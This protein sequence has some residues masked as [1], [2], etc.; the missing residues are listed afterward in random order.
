MSLA[1]RV[2][3]WLGYTRA[4]SAPVKTVEVPRARG[5]IDNSLWTDE[6][7]RSW[8][9]SD[10]FSAKSAH[11]FWVRRQLRLRSRYEVSNNPYLWG[12]CCNNA[13]DLVGKGPTLKVATQ[14]S[15]YNRKVE[16]AW[17]EWADEVCLAEKVRT[18]KL[19]R[20]VDGEGFLILKSVST[21]E[22][23]VQLY[24]LDVEADQVTRPAPA[25]LPEL[26]VDGLELD[27]V[28]GRPVAFWVLRHHPGDFWFPDLNP[29]AADRLPARLVIHWFP[30][31]R[32]GQV[33]GV[34]IFTP[35]LDLFTELRAYRK[36]VLTKAQ[37]SANLTGVVESTAP[38]DADGEEELKPFER[39]ALDRGTL[40]YLG[41]GY[42]MAPYPSASPDT[43]YGE[44]HKHCLGEACRPLAYPLNLALG[45]SQEFNF[46]SAKLDHINYFQNL[47]TERKECER[48]VLNHLFRAWFEE[49]VMVPGLLPDGA[50]LGATPV[51]WHWPGFPTLDPGVD[52]K[53]EMD[54]LAS[55]QKTWRQ[56]WAE[57]GQDWRDMMAQQAV[58][59]EEIE[60]LGLSFGEPLKKTE[61]TAEGEE[62]A[63]A[64][65]GKGAV[66]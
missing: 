48:V 1:S 12:V 46:S 25:S 6:N 3:G 43:G 2:A 10:Y 62:G 40:T 39:I 41:A 18:C 63:P 15:R 27:E 65:Q 49:A 54:E 32:P 16:A 20:T 42:K 44:F 52:V 24:P 64:G 9:Q 30:K 47:R 37:I 51:E 34:P 19:A 55:G 7:V 21:M 5:R 29:L 28:T 4:S 14:D 11:N 22:G 31:F 33:R 36:A 8:W 23:P 45:T 58:E 66:P 57:R 53:A 60:R 13:D 50:N 38:P 59:M 35:A 17:A 26:W 56:F 61:R